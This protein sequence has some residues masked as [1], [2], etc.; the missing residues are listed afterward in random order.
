MRWLAGG[1]LV[2]VSISIGMGFAFRAATSSGTNA[3]PLTGGVVVLGV[4][5]IEVE[6]EVGGFDL[7]D[8]TVWQALAAPRSE[9]DTRSL[10][11]DR[12]FTH[13]RPSADALEGLEGDVVY[14][15]DDDGRPMIIHA[16][17]APR[18]NPWDHVYTLFT[19]RGDRR[20]VDATFP[21]CAFSYEDGG[22]I[23]P[24][25]WVST[26]PD[27]W[28]VQWLGTPAATSLVAIAV[29]DEPIGFQRPAGGIVTLDLTASP[30]V[31][32]TLTAFD[33]LGRVLTTTD[34][35]LQ[36]IPD[37]DGEVGPDQ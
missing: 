25:A 23:Y 24:G 3:D 37:W 12:S 1:F 28:T 4:L 2:L 18:R 27:G 5:R 10:G 11:P 34:L 9:F 13:A 16:R 26:P 32:V 14:L 17:G 29:D 30:P 33:A 35:G 31:V 6:R 21:C 15:G 8:I 22:T 19:G 20:L 36:P 7:P